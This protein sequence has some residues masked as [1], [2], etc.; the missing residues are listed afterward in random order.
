[1]CLFLALGVV[2]CATRSRSSV[3]EV[4]HDP[5]GRYEITLPYREWVAGGPCN[6]EWPHRVAGSDW[7]Y[8]S[9]L[10][11]IIPAKQIILTHERAKT[12]YPWALQG[13][14][15]SIIFTNMEMK[16]N[17]QLPWYGDGGSN[18]IK[19]T[20]YDLNGTYKINISARKTDG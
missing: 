8:S 14:S 10:I 12:E 3:A 19:M 18:I 13:L 15:G 4:S 6:L 16:V 11:G 2:S 7:I 5:Q 9:N 17:L 1:V 20:P